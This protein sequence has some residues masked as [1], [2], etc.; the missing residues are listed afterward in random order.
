MKNYKRVLWV[1]LGKYAKQRLGI[2]DEGIYQGRPYPHIL[3]SKLR[4]LNLLESIRSEVQGHLRKSPSI[5]LHKYFH[6]LNSSQAL[7]FNLF[8]PYFNAQGVLRRH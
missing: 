2:F 8:F 6:H 3:P 7:T 5:K 4:F 1:H